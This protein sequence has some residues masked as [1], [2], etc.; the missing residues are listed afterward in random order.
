MNEINITLDTIHLIIL[1]A[2][3]MI[4][5]GVQ[6]GIYFKWRAEVELRHKEFDIRIKQLEANEAV[7]AK[8]LQRIEYNLKRL[9]IMQK[10]EYI[11]V[12]N[13]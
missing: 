9:F 1:I 12:D 4:T 3:F 7:S 5:L 10:Q 8:I 13:K 6:I 11:E 2:A